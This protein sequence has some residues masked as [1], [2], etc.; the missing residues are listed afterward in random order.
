MMT[1]PGEGFAE[2]STGCAWG[3]VTDEDEGAG[4]IACA[5]RKPPYGVDER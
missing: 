4:T 3:L 2:L 5:P 1:G